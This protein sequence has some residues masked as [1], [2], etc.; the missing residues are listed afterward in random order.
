M[1]PDQ[2]LF[3]H[4]R[5]RHCV[6]RSAQPHRRL[7]IPNRNYNVSLLNCMLTRFQIGFIT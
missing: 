7:A 3:K 6:S 5:V 2:R 1:N 4:P